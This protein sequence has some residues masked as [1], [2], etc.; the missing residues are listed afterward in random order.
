MSAVI[1]GERAA[2]AAKAGAGECSSRPPC[3]I[4]NPRSFR[5]SR[6]GLAE[7]AMA[8]GRS[9]GA[10]VVAAGDP[11]ELHE[12]LEQMLKN[13]GH[14]Q[15]LA[16]LAGDGTVQA[17]VDHLAARPAGVA[18]P[19]LLVL[20]GG[21]TNLTAWELGGRGAVLQKL[22]AA[23]ERWR[24]GRP[25]E[26]QTRATLRVE[27]S[28]APPR[29]GFFVA[30]GLIDYVIRACHA[31][32]AGTTSELRS[33]HVATPLSLLH[34]ALGAILGGEPIPRDELR[35]SARGYATP[36]LPSRLLIATTLQN[37]HG[38]LDPYADRGE[39]EVRF[40]AVG[41]RGAG[42]WLRLPTLAMGR[43]TPRMSPERG[44][45]SGRCSGLE[46]LGLSG[47]ALDGEKF[48]ADPARPVRIG[49]GPR[50]TFLC[51]P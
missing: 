43:F 30:A 16:V 40:T 9:H 39:G 44:F 5:A 50:L 10:Q 38:L 34:L 41:A 21:R 15:D 28:P 3:L 45:L 4:V 17:I 19:R 25:F 36:S 32:R 18:L 29:H 1:S 11:A 35:V 7:Q 13:P 47:Y 51:P 27:Q 33:G 48:E 22:A 6:G 20:G 31:H 14:P 12:A 42:F 23:L 2:P 37:R 46:V 24:E 26:A 49:P 8:L